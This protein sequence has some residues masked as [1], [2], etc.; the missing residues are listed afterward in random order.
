MLDLGNNPDK[1]TVH[2]SRNADF[3]P[4]LE[5]YVAGVATDYPAGTAVRLEIVDE[6]NTVLA[7]WD[8]TVTGNRASFAVDKAAVNTL[9]GTA[10]PKEGRLYYTN[11]SDDDLWASGPVRE[12]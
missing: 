5:S 4:R 1:M 10:G 12:H 7:S 3:R 11:G 6:T 9:L 8:A 2:L